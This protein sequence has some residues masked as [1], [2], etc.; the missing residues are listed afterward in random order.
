MA[1]PTLTSKAAKIWGSCHRPTRRCRPGA[2]A[3]C[4]ACREVGHDDDPARRRVAERAGTRPTARR[5]GRPRTAT[6]PSS[7]GFAARTW[8]DRVA[9]ARRSVAAGTVASFC[10]T[11]AD[12]ARAPRAA[13][14]APLQVGRH[15]QRSGSRCAIRMT[16]DDRRDDGHRERRLAGEDAEAAGRARRRSPPRRR[17]SRSGRGTQI[18]LSATTRLAHPGLA[19]RPG[20]QRRARRRRRRRRSATRPAPAIVIR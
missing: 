15:E 16:R 8:R 4:R 12:R 18:V 3:D 5:S 17:G 7:A 1:R 10:A 11:P 2:G 13:V 14:E 19:Q 9:H 6:A 20:L